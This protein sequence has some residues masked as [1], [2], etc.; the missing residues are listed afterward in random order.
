MMVMKMTNPVPEMPDCRLCEYAVVSDEYPSYCRS[1]EVCTNGN[2]FKADNNPM[3]L[4]QITS[5]DKTT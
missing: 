2:K 1:R 4:Y 5:E 3:Q